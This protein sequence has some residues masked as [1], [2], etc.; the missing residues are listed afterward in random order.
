METIEGDRIATS[1]ELGKRAEQARFF[2][3]VS[4]QRAQRERGPRRVARLGD[5]ADGR[6]QNGVR[7]DLDEVVPLLRQGLDGR[8]EENRLA[9]ISPPVL[10]AVVQPV[11]DLPGDGGEDGN[12][13]L[14][15]LDTREEPRELGLQRIHLRAVRRVLDLDP[16]A[17]HLTGFEG[18]GDL[19]QRIRLAGEQA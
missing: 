15:G 2:P 8:A 14:V 12:R 10:G 7:R 4:T 3:V 13:C 5:F 19:R 6:E 16:T 1:V 18:G 17:E 9:Q 11:L